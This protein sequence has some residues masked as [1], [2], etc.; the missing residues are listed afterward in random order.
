MEETEQQVFGGFAEQKGEAKFGLYR[1]AARAAKYAKKNSTLL[2]VIIVLLAFILIKDK[3]RSD[4]QIQTTGLKIQT[5]EH[6]AIISQQKKHIE[7][8]QLHNEKS[9]EREFS[10]KKKIC[11][12]A[13]TDYI[14]KGVLF[15]EP[16]F[17]I[18]AKNKNEYRWQGYYGKP[19]KFTFAKWNVA[20]RAKIIDQCITDN[21]LNSLAWFA[22][23]DG[24]HLIDAKRRLAAAL[25]LCKETET[26]SYD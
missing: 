13:E 19:H 12:L 20:L 1:N 5:A 15:D 26:A 8:L 3:W 17:Y 14:L 6:L 11:Q 7:T 10:Q 16:K 23:Q 22:E 2:L 4:K 24:W 9:D 25:V 18:A 21:K